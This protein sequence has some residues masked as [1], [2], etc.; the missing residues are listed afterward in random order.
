MQ[1]CRQPSSHTSSTAVPSPEVNP[2]PVKGWWRTGHLLLSLLLPPCLS[3]VPVSPSNTCHIP[4][5]LRIAELGIHSFIQPTNGLQP[6]HVRGHPNCRVCRA[7]RAAP[8]GRGH[9]HSHQGELGEAI[10]L[11]DFQVFS[12]PPSFLLSIFP[13]GSE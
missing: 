2:E 6:C 12:I 10:I 9:A 4:A 8:S 5:P 1:R 3:P 7:H 11:S 13:T